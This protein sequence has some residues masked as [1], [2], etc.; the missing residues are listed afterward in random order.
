VTD[1]TRPATWDDLKNVARY[2]EEAGAEYALVGG[3]ALA[4]HG[5]GRFT[6]DIDLL[7][8]PLADNSR[9]WIAALARLPDKAALEL[10]SAP[11]VFATNAQYAIRINDELTVDVMPS[12][13][14]H[15]W[16][17]LRPHIISRLID[18]QRVRL[19]D[20]PGLLLTKQGLRPKDQQDA[21]ILSAALRE[22]EQGD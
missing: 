9:R 18:G 7:V 12:V 14:G 1:Y 4:V 19:L 5:F 2:L 16:E 20:L 21:A 11:D 22:L 6:E 15:S 10:S 8:N 13:A 3:Y 17:A